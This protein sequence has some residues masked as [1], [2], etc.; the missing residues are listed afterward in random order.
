MVATERQKRFLSALLKRAGKPT[1]IPSDISAAKAAEMIDQLIRETGYRPLTPEELE[2]RA[3]YLESKKAPSDAPW[4]GPWLQGLAKRF[5]RLAEAKRRR[6]GII[7]IPD[8]E[9]EI[10]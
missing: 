7:P 10:F 3:Q 1:E 2:A 4:L 5:R 9:E 8:G 6:A